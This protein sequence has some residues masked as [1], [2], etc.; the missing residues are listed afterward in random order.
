MIVPELFNILL[1]FITTCH[2]AM[3]GFIEGGAYAKIE[4][5]PHSVFLY[6]ICKSPQVC[7]GSILTQNIILTAGHCFEN[8]SIK[9]KQII[10]FAGS[11]NTDEMLVSDD[12][13]KF[14]I[15]ED[16]D[17]KGLFNDIAIGY[18]KSDLPLGDTMKRII[19]GKSFP[20]VTM[21]KIAGW[22]AVDEGTMQQTQKLKMVTQILQPFT[23][24]L[25]V[26]KLREGM[27]C[28]MNSAR[29]HPSHGDSGSALISKNSQQIGLVS[30]RT[31]NRKEVVIYTNVSYY[32]NWIEEQ[33][34]HL[35]CA[36]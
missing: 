29:N 24:C 2:S 15:H 13:N 8:C 27:M 12:I 5:F 28:A 14:R 36:D 35:Q 23:A 18:L 11:E 3:E 21:A 1:L 22:G 9:G 32:Y 6:M 20:G 17:T 33:T 7:G 10:A 25:E 16:Y 31:P 30:F 19:I 26:I 34:R 4:N